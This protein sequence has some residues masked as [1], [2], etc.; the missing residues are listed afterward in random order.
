MFSPPDS[1]AG[2][3]PFSITH[4]QYARSDPLGKP[5]ALTALFPIFIMVSY[6]TLIAARRD[7][8]LASVCLGQLLGEVFNIALKRLIRQPRPTTFLGNGYGMPSSHAQFMS[9][10]ATFVVLH[11]YLRSVSVQLCFQPAH[12]MIRCTDAHA[13]RTSY[14]N[15]LW[16]HMVTFGVIGV[17]GVVAFSRVYLHY[18]TTTQV[19]A[20]I[21]IGAIL[22]LSWYIFTTRFLLP[23]LVDTCK[24][25]EHP[26][27]VQLCIRNTSDIGDLTLCEYEAIQR[28]ERDCALKDRGLAGTGVGKSA[29][30]KASTKKSN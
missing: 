22:G 17:A 21:Q 30:D 4:V 27:S 12:S 18:H 20:G 25:L 10:F 1:A 16:K 24:V 26:L 28:W 13:N 11:L 9:Y 23:F 5:L 19:L 2:L 29:M 14:K 15:P 6:A 3:K 7:L 8:Y